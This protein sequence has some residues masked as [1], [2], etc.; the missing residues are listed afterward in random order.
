MTKIYFKYLFTIFLCSGVLAINACPLT[1]NTFVASNY[2]GEDISCNAGNDG[3]AR[4]TV[5]GG[6][7]PYTYLWTGGSTNDSIFNLTAGKYYVT[8]TDFSLC[9]TVDS[10]IITE[11]AALSLSET[12]T[13]V[14][15]NGGSDGSIDITPSGGT[16]PFTYDWDHIVGTDDGEDV[17]TL[18]AGTYNVTVTDANSCTAA[19]SVVITEPAVLALSETHTDVSCNGGSDGSIDITPSGGTVPFTYDWDH[20]VGTDDGEDVNTLAAGTYNVTVTDVNSCTASSSVVIT[21]PAVLA[22]SETHTDVSCNG[23]SDGSID[24]TP[25]GGTGPFTYDWDHIVGTDDGEDV[26]TL[27]AGTYNVTVTDANSC[28]ASNSIVITEPAVLA[29]SETHTDV[30]CNGGSDGSIDITPSGGTGPF[31]YDWDHIV[32]TD[33]GEDVNTLAAGTY[34]VTVTDVNSCT[35]SNS[36]VITE[37][38]V[39]ALSETHT[40]VS[41]NGGSDGSIDITPS[42]GTGPFTYD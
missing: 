4:V 17:N 42:G 8:V 38:A 19:S 28:A 22:L 11:P 32:G 21:E 16:G 39:L 9:A 27:A 18:A 34:N 26:N 30:S 13:D 2:N 35:A 5:S 1:L 3:V 29:L 41:C 15:C 7:A 37:P 23:G 12:H 25:S 36:I 24:I 31:T 20:I 40:D 10:I 6:T 14:S 33:D